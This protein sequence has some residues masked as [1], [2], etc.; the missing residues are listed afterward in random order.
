MSNV[1]LRADRNIERLP[2]N[3]IAL[4]A[5]RRV[6]NRVAPN[7]SDKQNIEIVLVP[8]CLRHWELR[9]VNVARRKRYEARYPEWDARLHLDAATVWESRY[10]RCSPAHEYNVMGISSPPSLNIADARRATR[11][12]L[13]DAGFTV[14]GRWGL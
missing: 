10:Q 6:L 12:T 4:G 7:T 9:L 5:L 3:R 13:Q 1:V 14:R 2:L 8:D 11:Q